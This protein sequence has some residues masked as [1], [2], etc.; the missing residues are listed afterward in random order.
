VTTVGGAQNPGGRDGVA[1]GTGLFWWSPEALA[2]MAPGQI[3]DRD[4]VTGL[5]TTV[6]ARADGPA[7][8]TIDIETQM[9]GTSGR[10]TYDIGTG[11]LLRYQAQTQSDGTTI[12]L[13]LQGM[14]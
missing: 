3:L 9:P 10:V 7:G 5:Q 4:P 8:P 2:A 1:S 12:D 11:V 13:A 14:P 6:G